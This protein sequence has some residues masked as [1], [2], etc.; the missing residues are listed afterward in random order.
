MSYKIVVDSCCELPENF[1]NR[2]NCEIVPLGIQVDD[3]RILDD[4]TFNQKEFLKRAAASPNCPKSSCPSPERYM[5]AFKGEDENIYVV[6]LSAELSG[7]YNSAELAKNL[8][9]EENPK[10]NIHIFNSRSASGGET[11]IAFWVSEQEAKGLSFDEIV[12]ETE[13]KIDEMGTYFVLESL[14][15]LRKNGRLSNIKAFV[16]NT[17]N[18]KPVM[19]RTVQGTIIQLGQARGMNKALAKMIEHSLGEIKD[20]ENRRL[21]ITHCNCPERAEEVRRSY[22]AKAKFCESYVM[23]TR[24]ISTLY[25]SDGGIIVTF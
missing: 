17:L 25:A 20:T 18:I 21:I 15:A 14:E 11:Q 4:E 22:L 23:D 9:L 5:E 1:K 6:T 10:K 24:G 12:Q 13:K 3:Y 7:S 16:A 8:Y 2:V 19:G